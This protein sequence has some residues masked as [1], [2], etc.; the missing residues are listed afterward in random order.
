MLSDN[1]PKPR[2]CSW[3]GIS[4]ILGICSV[5]SYKNLLSMYMK[6]VAHMSETMTNKLNDLCKKDIKTAS[7]EELY[8]ALLKLVDEK[9]QQQVHSVTGRKLY[10]ISAE[11]LIGK[12]LSNNLI[13][14]GLYDDVKEA[15]AA[16]GKSL[17][18]SSLYR[19]S[20][21]FYAA[22]HALTGS[23]RDCPDAE[24][25]RR[26][27]YRQKCNHRFSGHRH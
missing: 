22:L 1:Q 18:R 25:L 17:R 15:L 24:S 4:G 6:G 14:L 13:N 3:K 16:A 21:T 19:A 9:S 23:L 12:L 10:Y 11:F 27:I 26:R 5:N 2:N 8:H 7:N 20:K